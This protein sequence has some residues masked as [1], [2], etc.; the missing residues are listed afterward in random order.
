MTITIGVDIALML[1]AIL[2]ALVVAVVVATHMVDEA[3]H[4]E[5][6]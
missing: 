6:E 1:L 5:D 3:H 4:R 2:V